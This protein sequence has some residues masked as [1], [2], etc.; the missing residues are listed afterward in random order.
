[1]HALPVAG[2]ILD[3]EGKHFTLF[4]LYSEAANPV[5]A[6]NVK[7]ISGQFKKS[8]LCTEHRL[9]VSA[10]RYSYVRFPVSYIRTAA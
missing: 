5:L 10:S 3:E 2:T 4:Y 9:N 1:M 6:G 7:T 8:D